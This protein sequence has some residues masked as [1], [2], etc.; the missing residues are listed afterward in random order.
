MDIKV[1]IEALKR[2]PELVHDLEP[3]AFEAVV[4]EL[5]ASRGYEV[6]IPPP[7]NEGGYD[8]LAIKTDTPGL[9][10]PWIIEC[11]KYKP[12]KTVGI[13]TVRQLV[14]V[15]DHLRI[16]NAAIVTTSDFTQDAK[17]FCS[18]RDDIRL[19]DLDTLRN[20]VAGYAAPEL[21]R[22]YTETRSFASCFISH[23]SRDEPFVSKLTKR[24]RELG[25]NVWYAPEDLKPGYEIFAEVKKAIHSFDKLIVVLSIDSMKSNW[26]QTEL[27]LALKRERDEGRRILFP[28]SIVDFEKIR[29]WTCFDSDTGNDIA[30]ELRK[31]R[32][33]NLSRWKNPTEFDGHVR[34]IVAA[35]SES[36]STRRLHVAADG[37]EFTRIRSGFESF[38]PWAALIGLLVLSLSYFFPS[39]IIVPIAATFVLSGAALFARRHRQYRLLVAIAALLASA[40]ALVAVTEIILTLTAETHGGRARNKAIAS[41]IKS[42]N[43]DLRLACLQ[44]GAAYGA[45]EALVHLNG[46]RNAEIYRSDSPSLSWN[47]VWTTS[48]YSFAPGGGGPGGGRDDDELKVGG[49]GDWYFSLIQFRL[50]QLQ[51]HPNFAAIALYSKEGE[52]ASVPLA[53][54]RLISNW[55]FTKGE[56]LWW[57]DRPG[58]RAISTDPLPAPKRNMW[59]IVELTDVVREWLENKSENYGIQLR[60]T[61]NF[62]SFA[63]FVSSDAADKTKIPRLIFCS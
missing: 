13:E 34:R 41:A 39:A 40:F 36:D 6:N 24:L 44:G 22:S 48:V 51:A 12:P 42:C 18:S 43:E 11:K 61:H 27:S 3:R 63:V 50:P 8:I 31:L 17:A 38:G 59:Y 49:W 14:G 53:L 52:G 9:K 16:A 26:V 55:S 47:D 28:I 1:Q 30:Q 21:Q 57:K 10:T 45:E 56:R 54:D 37:A 33:E 60:P 46:C 23:S 62:G 7:T 32:I 20:W 4:A 25:V 5:L 58:Q 2:E 29:E 15:R 35:L 19:I